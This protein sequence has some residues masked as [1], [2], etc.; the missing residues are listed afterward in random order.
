MKKRRTVWND[1]A[2]SPMVVHHELHKPRSPASVVAE[3]A[4]FIDVAAAALDA[5]QRAL[6][7]QRA[8][9]VSV[10]DVEPYCGGA[11]PDAD[12]EQRRVRWSGHR[13]KLTDYLIKP[14]QRI[15]K[16]PLLLDVSTIHLSNFMIA[17]HV[18]R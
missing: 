5:D 15:C 18:L 16:Y 7:L 14:V 3:E 11:V 12:G 17:V 13:L 6:G 9:P 4:A 10:P 8:G 1:L 2:S